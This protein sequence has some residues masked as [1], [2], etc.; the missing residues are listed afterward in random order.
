[1]ITPRELLAHYRNGGNVSA[2]LRSE[3]GLRSN[4]EEI[5]E[6]S[7]DLQA[8][9]YVAAMADPEMREHKA[10]YSAELADLI[11]GLG[12]KRTL[13]EVGV[14][15]GTT[16]SGV[17]NNLDQ[18]GLAAYGFDLCWS[19]VAHAKAWMASE[20]INNC[21]LFTGSLF[22]IP[23][24]DES[25]DIVYTSHSIEPNGGHEE[26]VL[27]ELFRVTRD[28]LILL[29]PGY[30]LADEKAK[31]RMEAHGYCRNLKGCAE[32]LGFDVVR[33]EL[34]PHI[35]NPLN[36]TALTIIKKQA[37]HPARKDLFACPI[38]KTP[39]KKIGEAYFSP[40]A[41]SVFPIIGGIPCLRRENRI[42]A[43]HYP[44][45]L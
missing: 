28:Y 2:L 16:L 23:L 27:K 41:L 44:D 22:H 30:E 29:E 39:L 21:E 36:P 37:E 25:I 19:R 10:R 17:L 8:G 20:N 34:F 33:H 9:S 7:Y 32:L 13:L 40:E 31:K 35:H 14:G 1:M 5:I 11:S 42:I 43:S 4:N 12:E 18:N 26:A 45:F 15:E 6:L 24:L 3:R 38:F